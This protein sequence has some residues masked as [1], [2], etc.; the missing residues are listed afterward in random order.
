MYDSISPE[1]IELYNKERDRLYQKGL[2]VV[3]GER[4]P[5]KIRKELVFAVMMVAGAF[6]LTDRGLRFGITPAMRNELPPQSELVEMAMTEAFWALKA[7]AIRFAFF[8]PRGCEECKRNQGSCTRDCGLV[9]LNNDKAPQDWRAITV[10]VAPDSEMI[11]HYHREDEETAFVK[12]PRTA[13]PIDDVEGVTVI[14]WIR[15]GE[16]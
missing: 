1:W 15:P 3:D 4:L 16:A 8:D 7:R 6:E 11:V 10:V 9:G 2:S 14:G 12:R 13:N 5:E